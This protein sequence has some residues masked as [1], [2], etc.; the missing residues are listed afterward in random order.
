MDE[1]KTVNTVIRIPFELHEKL[2][3]AAFQSRRSQHSIIIELLEK[4][5]VRVEVPKEAKK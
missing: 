5:L 4:G 2:R 3:W 1:K